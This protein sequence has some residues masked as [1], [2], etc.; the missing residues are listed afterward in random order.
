MPIQV[1]PIDHPEVSAFD[2]SDRFRHEVTYFMSVPGEGDTPTVG[3]NEYWIRRENA[4]QW[5]DDGVVEIVSPLDSTAKAEIELSEE[6]EAWLEWML[7][8]EI[9]HI[10]LSSA[11]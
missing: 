6:H 2:M 11:G 4:L 5:M 7:E 10:R 9:Q 3:E 8:H 1:V